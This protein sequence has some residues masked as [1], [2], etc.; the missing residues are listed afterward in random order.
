[1]SKISAA[2]FE[3]DPLEVELLH[4]AKR[5]ELLLAG[6]KNPSPDTVT[7]GVTRIEL[8]RHCKRK[9]RGT[10]ATIGLIESLFLSLL[11]STD[12]L[13]VPLLQAEAM[14]IWQTEKNHVAC[15]QDPKD[16]QLYTQTGA[17]SKGGIQLPVFMCARGTT[18]LES[19]HSHLKSFIP[20]KIFPPSV[21]YKY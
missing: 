7:K 9:T 10:D 5:N 19:F 18:S 14:D 13:G 8:A 1:M 3:W 16:V 11:N 2:I 6:V 21:Y 15:L 12:S 20:G 17:L 4:K